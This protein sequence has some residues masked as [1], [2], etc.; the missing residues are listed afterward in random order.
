MRRA[1]IGEF[2]STRDHEEKT[3]THPKLE[4]RREQP[5]WPIPWKQ[6]WP[7]THRANWSPRS[8][9]R[10]DDSPT[11]RDDSGSALL[12]NST[13]RLLRA[14]LEPRAERVDVRLAL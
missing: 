13:L 3:W 1:D 4:R 5:D 11:W 8:L 7:P 14:C 9:A 2:L 10:R 6:R 12:E